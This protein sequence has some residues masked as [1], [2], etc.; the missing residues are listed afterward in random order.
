MRIIAK[1]CSLRWLVL[2]S[3]LFSSVQL[4]LLAFLVVLLVEDLKF[5]LV[6]AGTVVPAV[7]VRGAIGRVLWGAVADKLRDG[8]AVLLGLAVI[9]AISSLTITLFAVELPR[10]LALV[11]FLSLGLSAV[12][13]NGVYLSEVA[14]LSYPHPVGATTGAATFFTF[15]GVVG[16]PP[17]FALCHGAFGG[18]TQ[19]YGLLA[20][21]ALAAGVMI[22]MARKR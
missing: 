22:N 12:G 19:T 1:S 11:P 16:G 14:R 3:F 21:M 17:V 6:T 5:D 20:F 9:M 7:Q 18:Y 2:S 10:E 15:A 8:I 13:W 4:C